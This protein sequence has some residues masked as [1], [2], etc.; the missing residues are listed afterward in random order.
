[1]VLAVLVLAHLEGRG[2]KL[3]TQYAADIFFL[4]QV[5]ADQSKDAVFSD[6]CKILDS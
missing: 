2:S 3:L 6:V 5:N 4:L 1:M